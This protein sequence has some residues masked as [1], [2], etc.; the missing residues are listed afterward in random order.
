MEIIM[1]ENFSYDLCLSFLK[2]SPREVLH[3][4]DEDTVT[5]ALS[6]KDQLIIFQIRPSH[7]KLQV[8]FLNTQPDAAASAEINNYIR[9]WF[10][11]DTDL[12]PFYKMARK[13]ELLKDLV[14]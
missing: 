14:K 1:P 6:V 10:D 4:I 13:D 9:E 2:R 7:E 12:K 5:K 8:D 11:L 3:R